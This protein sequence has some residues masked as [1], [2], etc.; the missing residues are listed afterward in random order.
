MSNSGDL[1]A[2]AK[3]GTTIPGDAGK[4]NIV[5]SVADKYQKAGDTDGGLGVSDLQKAADNAFSGSG[6]LGEGVTGTG[7]SL[8][9]FT[10]SKHSG[11]GGKEDTSH[12]SGRG[13]VPAS[14]V[15]R[16]A[17]ESDDPGRVL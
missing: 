16:E 13:A 14:K 2:M 10:T 6:G 5:P 17:K 11:H 4:Y 8:P 9:D 12:R 3:D 15:N 1:S 7:D